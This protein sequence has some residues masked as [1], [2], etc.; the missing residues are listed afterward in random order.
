MSKRRRHVL[1]IASIVM[2][3]SDSEDEPCGEDSDSDYCPTESSS[4]DIS[5]TSSEAEG[6]EAEPPPVIETSS[7]V[8]LQ[9]DSYLGVIEDHGPAPAACPVSERLQTQFLHSVYKWTPPNMCKPELPLF[10]VDAGCKVD[11][12]NFLPINYF[13]LFVDDGIL[14]HIVQQT[15][16]YAD[17]YFKQHETTT[18]PCA[19]VHRWFETN[20]CEMK[21]FWGLTLLMGIVQKPSIAS[22]WTKQHTQSTPIFHA[23]MTRDRFKLLQRFLHFNDNA[24]ALPRD[25][26]Q[27]DILFKLRP[28]LSHLMMRYQ[29]VYTPSQ[30]VAIKESLLLY[31]GHFVF[32]QYLPSKR[33]VH[34][35]RLYKL[36]ESSTGYTYRFRIHTGKDIDLPQPPVC[37]PD[38]STTE[39][40]VWD[41]IL[42]LFDKGYHLYMD[43]IYAGVPLFRMLHSKDTLACAI[44]CANNKDFP[45]KLLLRKQ[46]KGETSALRCGKLLAMK[47]TDKKDMYIIST[48]HD[49]ST[50]AITVQAKEAQFRK[51]KCVLEYNKHMGSV[52]ATDQMLQ[53]YNIAHKALVWYK[54][55]VVHLMQLSMLNAFL[56]Y[57]QTS[58]GKRL[59]FLKFQE[60]VI[61]SLLSET[62]GEPADDC[63]EQIENV[64]RLACR[65][66]PDL[67][68]PTARKERP[69]KRCRVCFRNGRRRETR[70]HCPDCPSK[71]GLCI[72]S[73]FRKYHTMLTY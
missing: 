34:G 30:N 12:S 65:H 37:C 46:K 56:V 32:K 19:K 35:I 26:S 6:M 39:K 40:I 8:S 18:E 47:Y 52:N 63:D 29:E 51:P 7:A 62:E 33:A 70:I 21:K 22:Y 36:C 59:S 15:N 23:I 41:L 50:S 48:I 1:D 49:E 20:L 73:C 66:F 72:P 53:P 64:A 69:C 25:H 17:Q 11:T 42:P 55:L 44:N 31:K 54:K 61:T 43:N 71:P 38:L 13:Q 45:L 57:N 24:K 16:L 27:F 68:P 9:H 28:V 2:P 58:S 10:T 14:E 5:D 60:S 3:G 67:L 4:G